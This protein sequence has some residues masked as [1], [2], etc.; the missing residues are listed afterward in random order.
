[1]K[2]L[3]FWVYKRVAGLI[4]AD[5]YK[6][7]ERMNSHYALEDAISG[8]I[9]EKVKTRNPECSEIM[10]K[11][12][13]KVKELESKGLNKGTDFELLECDIIKLKEIQKKIYPIDPAAHK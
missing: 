1:M 5:G 7:A 3:L 9:R 13:A 4:G 11:Q 8:Q 10:G 12:E 2:W 6:L